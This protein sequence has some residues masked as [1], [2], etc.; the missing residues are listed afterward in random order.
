MKRFLNDRV[1]IQNEWEAGGHSV[2]VDGAL[3]GH[4]IRVGYRNWSFVPPPAGSTITR[5]QV[6]NLAAARLEI[7]KQVEGRREK[8]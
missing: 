3:E 5:F 6:G 4:L 8:Q 7:M 1:R 2:T